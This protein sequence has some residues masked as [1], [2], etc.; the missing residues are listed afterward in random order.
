MTTLSNRYG[1]GA[2]L[3]LLLFLALAFVVL[4][5]QRSDALDTEDGPTLESLA[6][7][8]ETYTNYGG[9]CTNIIRDTAPVAHGFSFYT[10]KSA[11]R[12][13]YFIEDGGIADVLVNGSVVARANREPWRTVDISLR[14]GINVVKV[15]TSFT[16]GEI[17]RTYV[18]SISYSPLRD[19]TYTAGT[20][21]STRLPQVLVLSPTF[22]PEHK[23]YEATSFAT[24]ASAVLFTYRVAVIAGTTVDTTIFD[25]SNSIKR[26]RTTITVSSILSRDWASIPT[27]R[28]TE[29]I[30]ID[31]PVTRNGSVI[32]TDTFRYQFSFIRPDEDD[33]AGAVLPGLI[34]L[35][36]PTRSRNVP[37]GTHTVID[38]SHPRNDIDAWECLDGW[39]SGSLA[40]ESITRVNSAFTTAGTVGEPILGDLG[41]SSF[42]QNGFAGEFRGWSIGTGVYLTEQ[43]YT[44]SIWNFNRP[45]RRS[46]IVQFRDAYGV[47][48]LWLQSSRP[49]SPGASMVGSGL[50]SD[51]ASEPSLPWRRTVVTDYSAWCK[52]PYELADH[53]GDPVQLLPMWRWTTSSTIWTDWGGNWFTSKIKGAIGGGFDM[54]VG[55]LFGVSTLVWDVLARLVYLA[56]SADF[57]KDMLAAVDRT[58]YG[59]ADAVLNSGTLFAV[60]VIG[61][62]TTAWKLH[63]RGAQEAARTI[64][65]TMLPLG[66]VLFMMQSLNVAY[67]GA[68]PHVW[69]DDD[70]LQAPVFGTPAW[71][72]TKVITVSGLAGEGITQLSLGL[73][74][75]RLNNS[76]CSVYNHQL[77]RLYLQTMG[78][79]KLVEGKGKITAKDYAPIA[80]SRLWER[81][82]LAGWTQAQ[83]GAPQTASN[84]SCLWA[85]VNASGVSPPEIMA[86]WASTCTDVLTPDVGS[87]GSIKGYGTTQHLYGCDPSALP[88]G[89]IPLP[90]PEPNGKI[91]DPP[92]QARAWRTFHPSNDDQT[93]SMLNLISSC[94]L[95]NYHNVESTPDGTPDVPDYRNVDVASSGVDGDLR[96]IGQPDGTYLASSR[97]GIANKVGGASGPFHWWGSDDWR[98]MS[99]DAC[100]AWLTGVNPEG[101]THDYDKDALPIGVADGKVEGLGSQWMRDE[102]NY[103]CEDARGSASTVANNAL[104]TNASR[105]LALVTSASKAHQA[106]SDIC[107]TA[108]DKY[109]NRFLHA[110]IVMLT[111][112]SFLF[113]LVGLAT[114][115]ALAQILLGLIFMLLPLLLVV[116]AI[117]HSA[118][119]GILGRIFKVAIGAALAYAVFLLV[120]TLMVLIIDVVSAAVANATPP[121][122]TVRVI[123]LALIPFMAKKVVSG[124]AKQ[125][126]FD[127]TG[128]KNAVS[129]TSGLAAGKVGG[130]GGGSRGGMAQ[131]YG[132]SMA[133][134]VVS[135]YRMRS[136]LM[137][138][139]VNPRAGLGGTGGATAGLGGGGGGGV[140]G[141]LSG[142]LTG[143]VATA[144][145]GGVGAGSSPTTGSGVLPRAGRRGT[146]SSPPPAPTGH[147]GT[148]TKPDPWLEDYAYK[149]YPSN[150]GTGQ[151]E[152]PPPSAPYGP[153]GDHDTAIK[154][155]SAAY[156]GVS[157]GKHVGG[158]ALGFYRRHMLLTTLGVGAAMTGVGLP[159]VAALYLGAK[160]G[161]LITRG[162]RRMIG[163]KA[164]GVYT[165]QRDKYRELRD[166]V[167]GGP[168]P[169]AGGDTGA[170]QAPRPD[171]SPGLR[172]TDDGSPDQAAENEAPAPGQVV[173]PPSSGPMGGRVRIP[174]KAE[175]PAEVTPQQSPA[176][177]PR[178]PAP[179]IQQAPRA[180]AIVEPPPQQQSTPETVSPRPGTR[181]WVVPVRTSQESVFQRTEHTGQRGARVNPS[182]SVPPPTDDNQA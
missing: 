138:G 64:A 145:L 66:A 92:E 129:V 55:L 149:G 172:Q 137:G 79:K 156:R 109:F 178:Q 19:P 58:Y 12:L 15:R 46:V 151:S 97:A 165:G 76:Y 110:L 101:S 18:V 127:F 59:V 87:G 16:S 141:F 89:A 69:E 123:A 112:F 90:L 30:V 22:T 155:G 49:G 157:V 116:A 17:E 118:T 131:R 60:A 173:T 142:A 95:I 29:I 35:C 71:L 171:Q 121:G 75:D 114:G 122:S 82:Y 9:T 182:R 4:T 166:V 57:A 93:R 146:E 105:G 28:T 107:T 91:Y 43:G 23:T 158:K 164:K 162:P 100:R 125:F 65:W 63:S 177:P 94:G 21:G 6:V 174:P 111:A 103:D 70:F 108:G 53:C 8:H 48:V 52:L 41:L 80:I 51:F 152:A 117:P 143:A 62:I 37:G 32:R 144:G 167:N 169:R 163:N 7:C 13:T 124:L 40:R 11:L 47:P 104:D 140:G 99:V 102:A 96:L 27:G 86:I 42:Y 160:A 148:P 159:A 136:M 2:T 84:G 3:S 180:P 106:A 5:P 115:T 39:T 20:P 150:R 78:D 77:E 83:F 147:D 24:E 26:A 61:F 134:S 98:L 54:V 139:R 154:P 67:Q 36:P 68:T 56:L 33:D 14:P 175:P 168:G 181:G 119:R 85:E 133:R 74:E 1:W 45:Q 179:P 34:Y 31:V 120:L 135:P 73:S 10:D 130:G 126:G 44:V 38:V 72:H 176:E 113:S 88:D 50:H 128:L 170:R 81:T 25:E 132:R 153:Q 161:K